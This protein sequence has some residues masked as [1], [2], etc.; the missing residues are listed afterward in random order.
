MLLKTTDFGFTLA[1]IPLFYLIYNISYAGFAFTAGKW[2]DKFG[3]RKV[4]VAGYLLL[5]IG[6]IFIHIS[7]GA[8]SLAIGFLVLGLFPALTDGVQ[9]AFASMLSNQ[10]HRGSA[11]GFVN[12]ISGIGLLIAG[13]CGGYTWQ[14]WGPGTAFF[15]ASIFVIIGIFVLSTVHMHRGV[16]WFE[17]K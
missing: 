2:S 4:L 16:N 13:I 1:S 11:F 15:V 17:K 5:I 9:R 6:Y 8:V 3:P 14:I 7:T 12:G 10:D